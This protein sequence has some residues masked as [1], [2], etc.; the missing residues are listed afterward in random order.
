[1]VGIDVV[2]LRPPLGNVTPMEWPLAPEVDHAYRLARAFA[3][4]KGR[5]VLETTYLLYG[6]LSAGG[7]VTQWLFEAFGRDPGQICRELE[8]RVPG[9]E[10]EGEPVPT[11]H[12]QECM[13]LAAQFAWRRGIASVCE[14]DLLWAMLRRA[15]E[16]GSAFQTTCEKLRLEPRQLGAILAQRFPHPDGPCQCPSAP[17]VGLE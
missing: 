13:H 1:L 9:R 16:P 8:R 10:S 11:R 12:T 3:R 6:V 14:Q 5:A 2:A 4:R 7:E 17:S 15:E